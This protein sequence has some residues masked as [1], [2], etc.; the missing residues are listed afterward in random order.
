MP[1]LYIQINFSSIFGSI[2]SGADRSIFDRSNFI[3]RD[4]SGSAIL[5]RE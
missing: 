1:T 5:L 3:I 4:K 2:R